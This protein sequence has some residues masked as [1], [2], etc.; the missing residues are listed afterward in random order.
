M[1]EISTI[2]AE[3]RD[4]A[5]KGAARAT[6]RAGLVPGVIYGDRKDAVLIALDPR[7]IMRELNRSGFFARLF[8]VE[9]AG[10]KH[11]VLARDVQFDPV[12]D[13]PLHID[14][15]R[16]GAGATVHVNVPVIFLNQEK[17]PGMKRGGVLNI[18]RHDVELVCPANAIPD[19]ITIDLLG[20]D[21]G[22]SI[23]ISAVPLPEGAHPAITDR[24]FTIATIVPP[25][26]EPKSAEASA[27]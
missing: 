6:R 5:G 15:L 26:V 1:S 23:H 2:A 11:R 8:D 27:A 21:I 25:T 14:F 22:A 3:R 9:L 19:N 18:V 17:C 12:T 7:A 13:R 20:Y 16:V 10:E 4:R 24:D